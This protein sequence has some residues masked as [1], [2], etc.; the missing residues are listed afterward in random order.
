MTVRIINRPTILAAL[1]LAAAI[2]ITALA[3]PGS[4]SSDQPANLPGY[5]YATLSSVPR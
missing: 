5:P 4:A 3:T 1:V 2:A